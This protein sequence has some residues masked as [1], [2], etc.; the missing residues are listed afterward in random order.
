[1]ED[2]RLRRSCTSMSVKRCLACSIAVSSRQ[3]SRSS[4]HA[5]VPRVMTEQAR[6]S[7]G[8]A[9]GNSRPGPKSA[10]RKSVQ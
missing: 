10:I 7:S 2:S 3:R 5:M 4:F 6:A 9:S 1:M 8:P